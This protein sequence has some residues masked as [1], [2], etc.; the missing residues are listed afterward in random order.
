MKNIVMFHQKHEDVFKKHR[1][2]FIETLRC[3]H[4]NIAMYFQPIATIQ[5]THPELTCVNSWFSPWKAP[6]PY[7][8][9]SQKK[10]VQ[11]HVLQEKH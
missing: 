8:F 4:R 11:A 3:I 1:D 9:S 2:V 7:T 6:L 10:H 5:T